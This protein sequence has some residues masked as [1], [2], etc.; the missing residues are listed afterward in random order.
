M[1]PGLLGVRVM[2]RTGSFAQL[3]NQSKSQ[4]LKLGQLSKERGHI[5]GQCDVALGVRENLVAVVSFLPT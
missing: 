5:R 3:W 4:T 2:T 1:Q